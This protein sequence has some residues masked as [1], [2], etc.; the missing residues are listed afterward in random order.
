MV[1]DCSIANEKSIYIKNQANLRTLY[2]RKKVQRTI[3]SF[4][5][6]IMM[7]RFKGKL[8]VIVGSGNLCLGDWMFWSNC[9]VKMDF[10]E[11]KRVENEVKI[12]LKERCLNGQQGESNKIHLKKTQAKTNPKKQDKKL[13]SFRYLVTNYVEI[14]KDMGYTF[15]LYLEK[16]LRFTMGSHYKDLDEYLGINFDDYDLNQNEVFL[17]GSLPGAYPNYL[18]YS[19]KQCLEWGS[20]HF[21]SNF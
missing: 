7:V 12:E 19:S 20:A 6:K 10:L 17:V 21:L 9:F 18:N 3:G 1:S 4:H 5:P 13:S 15:Q 14:L 8:R 11:Q 16:Y 2:P